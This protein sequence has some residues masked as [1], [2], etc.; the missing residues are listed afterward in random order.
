ML[1]SCARRM[2]RAKALHRLYLSFCLTI[3]L[4]KSFTMSSDASNNRQ[5]GA[6][7]CYQFAAF[8]ALILAA[9]WSVVRA[10]LL[11]AFMP[12]GTGL[13]DAGRVLLSGRPRDFSAAIV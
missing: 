3:F 10:V 4:P 5:P 6:K 2:E 11:I 9:V 7:S 13:D 8:Q 12:G 1:A